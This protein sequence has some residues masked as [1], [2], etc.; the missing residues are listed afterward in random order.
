MN[1]CH[2]QRSLR[3]SYTSLHPGSVTMPSQKSQTVLRKRIYEAAPFH[4]PVPWHQLQP[5]QTNMTE[6]DDPA[7]DGL[8]RALAKRNDQYDLP[9]DLVSCGDHETLL[10][11]DRPVPSE[12]EEEPISPLLCKQRLTGTIR[13][14]TQI[15]V[16]NE[17]IIH[18]KSTW[19]TSLCAFD[20]L[21]SA[22][23]EARTHAMLLHAKGDASKVQVYW[24]NGTRIPNL[25][26]ALLHEYNRKIGV[27]STKTG[28]LF[29][30]TLRLALT[31]SSPI[32]LWNL[33]H[34]YRH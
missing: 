27:N 33:D 7:L 26:R 10:V 16:V 9:D 3:N 28:Y 12:P 5:R 25:H 19:S 15:Y 4:H 8:E 11:I 6:R 24:R 21:H 34:N 23:T 31:L 32:R 14:H 1:N 18:G 2:S 22:N 30:L 13:A 29:D 17:Q 20:N